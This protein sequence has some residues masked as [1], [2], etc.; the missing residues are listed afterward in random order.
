MKRP[1][2]IAETTRAMA[3]LN[4]LFGYL[5]KNGHGPDVGSLF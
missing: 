4:V 5:T 1:R 3:V 2:G